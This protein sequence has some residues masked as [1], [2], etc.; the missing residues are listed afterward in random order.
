MKL[1]ILVNFYG[2]PTDDVEADTELFREGDTVDVPDDF[3]AMIVAK[4]LAKAAGN[5]PAA[6]TE[7]KNET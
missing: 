4:E 6:K 7:A 2:R 3:G 5:K 1:Q